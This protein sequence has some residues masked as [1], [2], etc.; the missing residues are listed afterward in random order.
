MYSSPEDMKADEAYHELQQEIEEKKKKDTNPITKLSTTWKMILGGAILVGIWYFTTFEVSS[1]R[2]LLYVIGFIVVAY[3][4]LSGEVE[5]KK[6]TEK[7][8][9][10]SL[11]FKLREMQKESLGTYR[12]V[13]D[14]EIQI[15]FVG[16]ERWLNNRPWKR[17]IGFSIINRDGIERLF[18]AEINVWDG[19]IIGVKRRQD[20]FTGHEPR[21]T[22]VVMS[23]D[24][25]FE[26]ARDDYLKGGKGGGVRR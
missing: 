12:R 14:G 20:G 1:G 8:C 3:I 11:Y 2:M 16:R 19:D 23:R 6:L 22:E 18:S 21:D 17:E 24:I 7:Q 15:G 26:K 10:Q 9:A 4:L 13:P 5:M 25:R